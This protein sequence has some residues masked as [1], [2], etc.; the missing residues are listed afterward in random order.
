MGCSAAYLIA[1]ADQQAF[2]PATD[3]GRDRDL[4]SL[5]EAGSGE[6]DL[7]LLVF[8]LQRFDILQ[9]EINQ[10]LLPFIR[11]V[12]EVPVTGCTGDDYD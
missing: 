8:G 9:A 4:V 7:F 10:Y 11:I 12:R 5:D 1:F 2:D 3:L 6:R